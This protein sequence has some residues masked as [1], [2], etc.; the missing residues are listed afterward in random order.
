MVGADGPR[1]PD[2]VV[3]LSGVDGNAFN[4]LGLTAATMRAA[5]YGDAVDSFL[6]E[7]MGSGTYNEVLQTIMRWV[8]VE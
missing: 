5:G 4:L 6:A 1:Y 7:A 8:Q 3:R 2:V